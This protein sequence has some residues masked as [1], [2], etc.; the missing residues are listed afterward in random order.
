M[1]HRDQQAIIFS[2]LIIMS[3]LVISYIVIVAIGTLTVIN[4][5][6]GDTKHVVIKGMERVSVETKTSSIMIEP[7]PVSEDLK[8]LAQII[9]A[10]AGNQP[11]EGKLAVGNVVLNR[12]NSPKFP[13][14]I[15]DVVYQRGQ[16]DPVRDGSIHNTPSDESIQAAKEVMNGH[17]VVHED[18]LFFYNPEISTSD[19]IFTRTVV[20]K[21]GEHAFTL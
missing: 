9:N 7:P 5:V 19:W 20:T 21:I 3:A 14:T 10:E 16:F 8:I 12:V 6:Q 11:Y 15:K 18:V 1:N 2:I 4:S 13:D 17:T